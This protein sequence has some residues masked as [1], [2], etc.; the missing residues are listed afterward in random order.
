MSKPSLRVFA[1]LIA[2][3][4]LASSTLVTTAGAQEQ[5]QEKLKVVATFSILE[6]IV[7]NVGGDAIELESI[8][9][10][11]GDAH[12]F[13]PEPDQ[14]ASVGDADLVVEIGIGFEPWL[15]DM[16]DAS[17]SGAQLVTVTDGLDLIDGLGEGDHE[18]EASPEDEDHAGEDHGHDH[19]TGGIDPHVWGDV[20]NVIAITDTIKNALIGADPDNSATYEAN[21]ASYT[22]QL[23]ELDTWVRDQVATLPE[24]QR[25]LV[26]SHDTF[27]YFA[28]AYGFEVVGTAIG[29]VTTE[30][31]DPS[32][33]DIA[34]LV[35]QIESTGVTAIFA[36]N[37]S[38]PDLID[39]IASEAGVTVGPALY[40]DALG[41]PGSDGD[42][43][44]KLVTWNVTSI[45][46]ALS[47]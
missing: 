22:T 2:V 46:T 39:A 42:T 19:D 36:E 31:G 13:D 35:D 5:D 17:G 26:T 41:E 24:D 27:G 38:N 7:A 14:V 12:S 3:I 45:V 11:G 47:A 34:N 8:V 10:A 6:D 30:S 40:T 25:K 4:W 37:V 9:P 15:T 16:I 28:R 43:Y 23:Q 44:I 32:A 20:A 1:A 18:A 33:E 29:S 21:A